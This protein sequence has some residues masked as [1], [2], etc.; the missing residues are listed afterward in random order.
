[1]WAVNQKSRNIEAF[2]L[3]TTGLKGYSSEPMKHKYA[4]RG[5]QNCQIVMSDVHV[6]EEQR[7]PSAVSFQKGTNSILQT[8]RT[9]VGWIAIGCMMGTYDHAIAY[10]TSRSQFGR[11]VAGTWRQI[12]VSSWCKRNYS[13]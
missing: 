10:T 5:M 6:G 13:G 4:A 3:E 2:I 11:P 8:S 1:M 7:L 9:A 12:K